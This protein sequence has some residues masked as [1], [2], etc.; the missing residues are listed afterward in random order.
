M[1]KSIILFSILFLY[2]SISKAQN[3]TK[4][5][6]IENGI[7]LQTE[8]GDLSGTLCMPVNPKQ[9]PVALIIAGSGPTDRNGN[10]SMMQ[11]N[12]LKFLAHELAKSGIAS[13]RYDKRGIGE[14]SSIVQNETTLNFEDYIQDAADW[15][16]LLKKD[17]R[18]SKV[19]VIGHSEGSLIGM[20]AAKSAD[21]YISVA[22]AG[23]AADKILKKQLALQPQYIKD[24]T[25]PIIDS[26]KSRKQVKDVVPML[27]SLF[28]PSVQPYLISWFKYDP[29]TEIKKLN[30]PILIVQGTK[31]IQVS[32]EDAK[33]LAAASPEARLILIENMNHVF[34]I[35]EVNGISN[36]E[37]YNNPDLPVAEEMVNSIKSFIFNF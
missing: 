16:A 25:T 1:K 37:G 18:F 29:Q 28:R 32:T 7:T 26:L 31:D 19:I 11:N 6:L 2:T 12:S 22:G 21:L 8:T 34:K 15:I 30:I 27:N 4:P 13:V 9:M 3:S 17:N 33:K 20:I 36:M 14:S 35:V 10:N 5:A 23:D 24:M